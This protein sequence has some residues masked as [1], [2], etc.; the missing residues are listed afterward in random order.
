MTHIDQVLCKA[1]RTIKVLESCEHY[2]Q[3]AS[4]DIRINQIN[5]TIDE[6]DLIKERIFVF[7]HDVLWDK[8]VKVLTRYNVI[9]RN[10]VLKDSKIHTLNVYISFNDL[11]EKMKW[12]LSK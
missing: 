5:M 7:R 6:F 9:C 11:S 1:S 8:S 4:V 2:L 3:I 12:K 10:S